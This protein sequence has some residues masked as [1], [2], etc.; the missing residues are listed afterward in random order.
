MIL[1]CKICGGELEVNAGDKV[2]V[3][4]YCGRTQTLP[5]MDDERRLNLY[6]RASHFRRNNEYDKAMGIYE[7]ILS[8]D[9]EDAEAYWSLLLCKYGVE[10]VKDPATKE[11]MPTCNRTINKSILADEDYKAAIRYAGIEAGKLYEEEAKKLEQIQR[12]ILAISEKEAAY[13]IFICYK[14][15][16]EQGRRT[17]DSVMAQDIYQHLTREGYRVFFARVSL[18]NIVGGYEPYIY[19]A[20]SSARVMLVIGT[21]KDYFNAVWVKNEWSRF[22]GMMKENTDKILIPVCRDMDP[23]DLPDEL[24]H[25]QAQDMGKIGFMQDL[26]HG[27]EKVFAKEKG[28]AVLD[29]QIEHYGVTNIENLLKRIEAFL[30]VGDVNKAQEYCEKVLDIKIDEPKVYM[31]QLRIECIKNYGKILRK[32]EA[33]A[34]VPR[35]I[36][37]SY[38]FVNAQKYADKEYAKT[39]QEL[40]QRNEEFCYEECAKAVEKGEEKDYTAQLDLIRQFWISGNNKDK[41]GPLLERTQNMQIQYEEDKK[42]VEAIRQEIK[43]QKEILEGKNI[44]KAE[45]EYSAAKAQYEKSQMLCEENERLGADLETAIAENEAKRISCY[46]WIVLAWGIF[47][48]IGIFASQGRSVG[49][50]N[51]ISLIAAIVITYRMVTKKNVLKSTC[52]EQRRQKGYNEGERYSLSQDLARTKRLYDSAV[53]KYVKVKEEVEK[54][55]KSLQH[56]SQKEQEITLKMNVAKIDGEKLQTIKKISPLTEG[57]ILQ[58]EVTEVDEWGA[59]I[60]LEGGESGVIPVSQ[61]SS[62]RIRSAKQVLKVGSVITAMYM[63]TDTSGKNVFSMK[64]LEPDI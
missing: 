43:K 45:Q 12:D 18:E 2:A 6:D 1:K 26:L 64:A 57:S 8:E 38:Y 52:A 27:L 25:L 59:T 35:N 3:C 19:A 14:E 60:S 61:I 51:A 28:G 5:K 13:D 37:N 10:Y 11:W 42:T 39:L 30:E 22:L 50:A 33:V 17:M 48:A 20:L 15:S 54:I 55:Q 40:R 32:E 31:A 23:Y 58:A 16:N 4:S 29:K 63:G 49:P 24:L 9:G 41:W 62:R 21:N 7:T 36:S 46:I 34:L 47:I 56:L 44:K 53:A